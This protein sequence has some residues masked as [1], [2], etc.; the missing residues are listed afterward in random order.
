MVGSYRLSMRVKGAPVSDLTL[1]ASVDA[2]KS[3][4]GTP[5][6]PVDVVTVKVYYTRLL[7]RFCGAVETL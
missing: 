6:L 5:N 1:I 3:T 2:K 4:T 7:S